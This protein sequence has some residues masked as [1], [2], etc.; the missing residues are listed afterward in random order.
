MKLD[1]LT[2]DDVDFHG[3]K[4]LL[5][6]D[7]NVPLDKDTGEISDDTR[8][9]ESLETI[10]K[11]LSNNCAVIACSHLGRP[12]GGADPKFS[13]K[14]VAE[15]FSRLLGEEVRFV[16]ESVGHIAEKSAGETVP[17][18]MLLLENLR[19]HP[20]EESND[21]VFS[22][23]LSSLAQIYVNDAFGTAH[24]AH[25]STYGAALVFRERSYALAG[26]LMKREVEYL[27]KAMKYYERPV[28]SIIGGS[29]ITGKIEL[30][31]NFAR[32][33]DTILIGGG[34]VYTFLKAQGF[35]IGRSILDVKAMDMA[36][37][38]I[39]EI[40]SEAKVNFILPKDSAVVEE[41]SEGAEIEYCDN[42]EIPQNKIGVDIG[43][44]SMRIFSKAI[45]DAKTIIWN[46]PMGIFEIESF[47][48]G[49]KEVAAAVAN[50]TEKGSLSVIGGGDTASAVKKFGMENK[51]SHISTGGGASLEFMAGLPMPSLEALSKR[52]LS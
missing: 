20:E 41:I 43:P 42:A 10:K 36:K 18:Q 48:T 27:T 39:R 6:G 45:E 15:R 38:I 24:R 9:V 46:G 31:E 34:M 52:G 29:K 51:F 26:C 21:P 17:G 8:L 12:K 2:L 37:K 49:T 22:K 14:P 13:L 30:I 7:F 16:T 35:E 25:A 33:A 3:K 50:A 28:V 4:V 44:L 5:R 40:G 47:S 1:F 32:F 19:F 23:S 11:L